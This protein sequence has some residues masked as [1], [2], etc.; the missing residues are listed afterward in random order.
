MSENTNTKSKRRTR[1]SS[2]GGSN[3]LFTVVRIDI[4]DPFIEL[5]SR[6][7]FVMFA[8]VIAIV[9]SALHF[10]TH[11]TAIVPLEMKRLVLFFFL[12]G[13]RCGHLTSFHLQEW[14]RLVHRCRLIKQLD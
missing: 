2:L 6:S 14:F 7:T 4:P 3:W 13:H 1:S 8:C 5:L 9:E 11:K 10:P 12:C